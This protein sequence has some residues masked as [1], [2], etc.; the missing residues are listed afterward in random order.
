VWTLARN[1]NCT[2][3]TLLSGPFTAIDKKVTTEEIE[4]AYD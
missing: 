1:F 3:P 4:G 2:V